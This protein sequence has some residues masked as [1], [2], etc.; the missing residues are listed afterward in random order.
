MV[1]QELMEQYKRLWE[2]AKEEE[3]EFGEM[4]ESTENMIHI[5]ELEMEMLQAES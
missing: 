4:S 2:K 1:M 3:A 5:V